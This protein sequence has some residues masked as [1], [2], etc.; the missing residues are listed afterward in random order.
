MTL[1]SQSQGLAHPDARVSGV[2]HNTPWL[3]TIV[4][5]HQAP[6]GHVQARL[7]WT[8]PRGQV[9]E[10]IPLYCLRKTFPTN[11]PRNIPERD[12]WTTPQGVVD[13]LERLHGPH[14]IDWFATQAN[15]RFERFGSKKYEP[16]AEWCDSLRHNRGA[17]NG[18]ANPPPSFLSKVADKLANSPPMALTLIA[19][20]WE[21]SP[22]F[23]TFMS[24]CF[25]YEHVAVEQGCCTPSHPTL[26]QAA[27]PPQWMMM[28]FRFERN[29]A[30][31]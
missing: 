26:H 14:T 10:V 7:H 23:G 4:A 2:V 31:G 17:H 3:P 20:R 6:D 29:H 19:L 30:S 12:D 15:K 13:K 5:F 27:H 25:E 9:Q 22:W 16:E 11:S 8:H 21:G 18:W 1:R 24:L 28:A